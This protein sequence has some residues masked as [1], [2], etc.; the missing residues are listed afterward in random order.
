MP[1]PHPA[2]ADEDHISAQR[3]KITNPM[4][5]SHKEDYVRKKGPVTS[6]LK[7]PLHASEIRGNGTPPNHH[8][9]SP[10]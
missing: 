2:R 1:D 3:D 9:G 4:S 8:I 5:T 6:N 10:N 7:P